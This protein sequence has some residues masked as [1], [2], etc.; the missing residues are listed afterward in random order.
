MQSDQFAEENRRI[1]GGQ[2]EF[3]WGHDLGYDYGLVLYQPEFSQENQDYLSFQRHQKAAKG[4]EKSQGRFC[5]QT[6][7]LR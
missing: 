7:T 2:K 6:Q 4:Y 5:L 3:D 1:F